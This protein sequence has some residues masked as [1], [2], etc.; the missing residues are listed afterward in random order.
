MKIC[1]SPDTSVMLYGSYQPGTTPVTVKNTQKSKYLCSS[2]PFLKDV[3]NIMAPSKPA[4]E[5]CFLHP[6]SATGVIVL[7]LCVCV[8][9]CYHS[10]AWTEIVLQVY[11]FCY[12]CTQRCTGVVDTS[13]E[14]YS[15][16][17]SGRPASITSYMNVG[18][19]TR[20]VFE[21]YAFFFVTNIVAMCV[22]LALHAG[23]HR[24]TK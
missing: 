22:S 14:L 5:V 11:N 9:V 3:Y 4:V 21:A 23:I 8:C 6:V 15:W 16:A 24:R 10:P 18:P 17:P 2:V 1:I 13:R 12:T 7:A 20:G 19:T